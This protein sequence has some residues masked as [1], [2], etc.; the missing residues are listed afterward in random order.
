MEIPNL[1]FTVKITFWMTE[2]SLYSFVLLISVN[3]KMSCASLLTSSDDFQSIAVISDHK[4]G[5]IIFH[6]EQIHF[7]V[8]SLL[9]MSLSVQFFPLIL[10]VLTLVW[11]LFVHAIPVNY[12][13]TPL[14]SW[15]TIY[16]GAAELLSKIYWEHKTHSVT[17]EAAS[18]ASAAQWHFKSGGF[19]PFSS[20][21]WS[22]MR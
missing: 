16:R 4:R 9:K 14:F 19:T 12:W 13:Y 7:R 2:L 8:F 18:W 3:T 17:S 20:S 1:K 21:S 15:A 22:F 10:T 6:F 11:E 5:A